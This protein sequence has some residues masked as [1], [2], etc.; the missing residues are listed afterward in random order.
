MSLLAGYVES[1]E[2]IFFAHI[3]CNELCCICDEK[4]NIVSKLLK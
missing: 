3:Q 1:N 4:E 2:E